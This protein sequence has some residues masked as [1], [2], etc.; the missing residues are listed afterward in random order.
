MWNVNFNI[1]ICIS[2]L[3]KTRD[4]WWFKRTEI[5]DDMALFWFFGTGWKRQDR[6][7]HLQECQIL[8][9]QMEMPL[10]YI[11]T[12]MYPYTDNMSLFLNWR[13]NCSWGQIKSF[14]FSHESHALAVFKLKDFH[15]YTFFRSFFEFLNMA[16]HI[17][18]QYFI[19]NSCPPVKH[20]WTFLLSGLP[21]SLARPSHMEVLKESDRAWLCAARV[22]D[23]CPA[24]KPQPDAFWFLLGYLTAINS[25]ASEYL[26]SL[27]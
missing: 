22:G 17:S 12:M 3:K 7:L 6:L 10:I 21:W 20:V 16:Q 15:A 27:D 26:Q 25:I 14:A 24:I 19:F 23:H 13:S 8:Q 4:A 2:D 1:N 18:I 5:S 11:S 9:R